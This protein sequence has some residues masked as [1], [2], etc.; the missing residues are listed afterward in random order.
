MTARTHRDARPLFVLSKDYG[1]LS[2]AMLFL[3]GQEFAG[4]SILM[5]PEPVYSTNKASLPAPVSPYRSLEDVL[6]V[7]ASHEPDLVL[8]LSGYLFSNDGLLS[9][10]SLE[11]LIRHLRDRGCAVLTSDPFVGLASRLTGAHIDA[12]MLLAG[13]GPLT[14]W[15]TRLGW[16]LLAR[17]KK[18]MRRRS[19]D[20]LV[21]L[22][23]TWSAPRDAGDDGVRRVSF[24]NP[25]I[26]VPPEDPP[27]SR[28]R[29]LYVLSSTDLE[30]QHRLWGAGAFTGLVLRILKRTLDRGRRPTLIAPSIV[31]ERLSGEIP[32]A[33]GVELLSF[34]PYADFVSR[35]LEAEYVFYWNV[36]SCSLLVRLANERPVFFFD[37]G[38]LSRTIKPFYEVAL[39]RH[40]GSWEPV[41]L[42][43]ERPLDL[44]ELEELA[45]QQ[46]TAL[47]T[48]RKRWEASPSPTELLDQL[49]EESAGPAGA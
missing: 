28:G 31:A 45:G 24:F 10:E 8:L 34:C 29:W 33:A 17:D 5:L 46:R 42:D 39:S 1:E 13:K 12:R 11:R 27:V 7:V 38:H 25:A 20:D 9:P 22:Y 21:H 3:Q 35:L 15:V 23:P 16:S 14:R 19:L 18:I 43:P 32:V 2:M 37:R 6:A 47:S 30:I 26:L 44:G 40:F 36:F 49:L 4:R 48:I 41:Y